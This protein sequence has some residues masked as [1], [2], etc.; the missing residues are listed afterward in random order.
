MR[1]PSAG[2]PGCAIR[3][4]GW[5]GSWHGRPHC[6]CAWLLHQGTQGF[7]AGSFW[8][9]ICPPYPHPQSGLNRASQESC[10]SV[11]L[12][13]SV[14]AKPEE[15][16]PSQVLF[17]KTWDASHLRGPAHLPLPHQLASRPHP[18]HP[19]PTPTQALPT[20]RRPRTPWPGRCQSWR[21]ALRTRAV[22]GWAP[23]SPRSVPRTLLHDASAL[24]CDLQKLDI[25]SVCWLQERVTCLA[26]P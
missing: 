23:A 12:L 8:E 21:G 3:K 1:C 18:H 19:R 10:Q 2:C 24:T 4:A 22:Q 15:N 5:I 17:G 11:S 26:G 9:H 13:G 7:V 20:S 6:P 25:M 14:H 16:I